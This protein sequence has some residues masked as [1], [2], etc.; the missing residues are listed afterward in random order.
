MTDSNLKIMRQIFPEYDAHELSITKSEAGLIEAVR[1]GYRF[2][3]DNY[4]LIKPNNEYVSF[5]D[6]KSSQRYP[7]F[8]FSSFGMHFK[9]EIHRL[10]A[11][12]KY[13]FNLFREGVVVR[14][15]DDN[16]MNMSFSNIEIGTAHH[17]FYDI[18]EKVRKRI[19]VKSLEYNTGKVP[20]NMRFSYEDAEALI[21]KYLKKTELLTKKLGKN[22][23]SLFIDE[24]PVKDSDT[25]TA[26]CRGESC[27]YS[28]CFI[29][30][31]YGYPLTKN[32]EKTLNESGKTLKQYL[33]Q[34]E[35]YRKKLNEMYKQV[36]NDDV[37]T[38]YE[39]S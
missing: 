35:L 5:K 16:P 2:D 27:K 10:I 32:V 3:C 15:K 21:Y 37:Y 12:Q 34:S 25:I 6:F 28:W 39:E 33:M 26:I 13:G 4:T 9:V 38:I 30:Y 14:H 18:D 29:S 24:F 17:N 20:K 36:I 11:Y 7:Y 1:L 22:Y 31:V 19:S 8:Q 23:A